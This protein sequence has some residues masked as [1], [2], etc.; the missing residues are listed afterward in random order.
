MGNW[1]SSPRSA[2]LLDLDDHLLCEVF[3]SVSTY[4]KQ[5]HVQ[6]ACMRFRRVLQQP[7]F[8]ETWGH[9]VVKMQHDTDTS[10]GSLRRL[11]SWLLYRKS[12][13]HKLCSIVSQESLKQSGLLRMTDHL[14]VRQAL[15]W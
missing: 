2:T 9:V 12:G 5:Q 10:P 8:S 14:V 6:R 7:S 3:K 11:I 13:T 4:D 1:S 15:P